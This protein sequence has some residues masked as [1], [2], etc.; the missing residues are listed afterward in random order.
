MY[1]AIV[2]HYCSATI[3]NGVAIPVPAHSVSPACDVD[4]PEN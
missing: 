4:P 1:I 3:S 2:E